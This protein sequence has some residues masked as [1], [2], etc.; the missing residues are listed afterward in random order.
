MAAEAKIESADQIPRAVTWLIDLLQ[1]G[2]PGGPVSVRV[3]RYEESRT[4]EQNDKFHPMIRDIKTQHKHSTLTTEKHWREF[5]VA[6]FLGQ[7]M[8]PSLDGQQ[9]IVVNKR[10]SSEL[11]KTEGSEFIEYLYSVGAELGIRWSE[12]SLQ[13]F[14]QYL[15]K[16]KQEDAA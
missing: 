2:L 9:L 15:P 16:K 13:A 4:G 3:E 11:K 1:R 5:L 10:G 14:E 8:V 7:M 12:P 6:Q